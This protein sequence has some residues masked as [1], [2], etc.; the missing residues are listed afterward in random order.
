MRVNYDD[1]AKTFATSRSQLKWPEISYILS[2]LSMQ[3]TIIDIACG[4]WRLIQAFQEHFQVDPHGYYWIDASEKLLQ[5]ARKSHPW[6][7]FSCWNMEEWKSYEDIY[8][9]FK[10]IKKNIFCIAW[11]H[12][13]M[14]I[15]DRISTMKHW[16]NFLNIW[17]R[18][19]MINWALESP[20]NINTYKNSMIASSE[21][22]FWS[23]DFSIKIWKYY[24]WYHSFTL[25]EL[26]YL[27][28]QTKFTIVENWLFVGEKNYITILER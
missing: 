19:F 26:E 4:S 12:H 5:E 11:F 18:V 9:S 22:Q 25:S 17:E 7:T 27:A 21:N 23:H 16:Y 8:S 15:D 13:I 14:N 20:K 28:N 10:N 24:R 1:F 2:Q 3:D 6:F